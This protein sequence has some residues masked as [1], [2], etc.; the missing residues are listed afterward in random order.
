LA[1][2]GRAAQALGNVALSVVLCLL[3]VAAGHYGAAAIHRQQTSFG[4]IE[5]R[6]VLVADFNRRFMRR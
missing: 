5:Q 4:V 1:L 3:A 2:G 6:N